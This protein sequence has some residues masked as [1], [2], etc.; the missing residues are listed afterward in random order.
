MSFLSTEP[1]ESISHCGLTGPKSGGLQTFAA[2][3]LPTV[4]A[5]SIL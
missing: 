1:V 2:I 4:S 3:C 5:E